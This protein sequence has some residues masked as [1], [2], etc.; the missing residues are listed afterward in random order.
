MILTCPPLFFV[1]F[2]AQFH[3]TSPQKSPYNPFMSSSPKFTNFCQNLVP[4]SVETGRSDIWRGLLEAKNDQKLKTALFGWYPCVNY[5]LNPHG[6]GVTCFFVTTQFTMTQCNLPRQK[7]SNFR[8][9]IKK[10]PSF[11]I[12]HISHM[13]VSMLS[14][15]KYPKLRM[16]YFKCYAPFLFRDA[17]HQS[18]IQMSK[19]N[20]FHESSSTTS[21]KSRRGQQ[22][23]PSWRK[24]A[25]PF[26][27]K[28]SEGWQAHEMMYIPSVGTITYPLQSHFW[29]DAFPF[30]QGYVIVPWRVTFNFQ[31]FMLYFR[32]P[33]FLKASNNLHQ[34][35]GYVQ[36]LS[37]SN[38]KMVFSNPFHVSQIGSYQQVGVNM[39]SLKNHLFDLVV[40]S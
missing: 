4:K 16:A 5:W 9:A 8:Y 22:A 21:S 30:P 27:K 3:R 1:G 2:L 31:G 24:F 12:Y 23:V 25:V 39:Q 37:M 6:F 11:D 32:G 33:A 19:Q 17:T 36:G 38:W 10:Y 29:V 35:L 20:R 15:T 13:L 28:T 7:S 40:I 14:V 26:W 34:G 18:Y